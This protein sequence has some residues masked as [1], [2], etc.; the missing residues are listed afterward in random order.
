[1]TQPVSWMTYLSLRTSILQDSQTMIAKSSPVS[2]ATYLFLA[3]TFWTVSL[4]ADNCLAVQRGLDSA[5]YQ[6]AIEKAYSSN[7]AVKN[8]QVRVVNGVA[9][10]TL[11]TKK[12]QK[13]I[14]Q[15]THHLMTRKIYDEKIKTYRDAGMALKFER[16]YIVKGKTYYLALWEDKPTESIVFW[17]SKSSVPVS[18]KLVPSLIPFDNLM[19]R[20]L[21]E[22]QLPGATLAVSKNGK[23]ILA[24]GYGFSDFEKKEEMR[25]NSMMRIASIS[26]PLTAAAIMKLVEQK[27]LKLT[28]KVFS[29][30][31]IQPPNLIGKDD[32]FDVRLRD[33]TVEHCL[34]HTGGWD[35]GVSFDPMFRPTT[36]AKTLG[37]NCPPSK[38]DIIRYMLRQPLDHTPGTKYAYSNFGYNVLGR[39]I[40]KV[41]NVDYETFVKREILSPLSIKKTMLGRTL[42]ENRKSGEVIYYAEGNRYRSSVVGVIGKRVLAPYG[43][44]DL[45][46]MDAH[47]GWISTAPD[48]VTFA[49]AFNQSNR[50]TILTRDSIGKI[51]GRPGG[52]LG[53]DSRGAP[54]SYF[55]GYGW[56]VRPVGKSQN[57]WHSGKLNGT[58]TL[59]VRR[60]DGLNWAVLFNKSDCLDGG[61]PSG[62]IDSL[63]HNAAKQVKKWPSK[64]VETN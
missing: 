62:K 59:L 20:F 51:L 40:Q 22:N 10:Y 60:Y 15:G 41:S 14:R 34:R 38:T 64:P 57:S 32:S 42:K 30:L 28:D 6:K 54:K 11:E 49:N 16:E 1:M 47:G 58:S 3:T 50:S 19:K 52:K 35:R 43:A 5:G 8:V 9:R 53:S 31:K 37:V 21:R 48:L 18:G 17:N 33:V 63:L 23:L 61:L 4:F 24:R 12:R 56:M 45:E 7:L 13:N 36:I 29:I 26:K 55:Y 46:A 39:V 2:F 27:K 25:P 44:W